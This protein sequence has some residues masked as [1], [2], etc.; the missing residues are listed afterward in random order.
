MDESLSAPVDP[1]ATMQRSR[2]AVVLEPGGMT[3]DGAWWPRSDSL[4]REL[5]ALDVAI[6]DTLGAGISRFSYVLGNW[7]DRPRRIRTATHLIKF[8]WFSHGASPD[9]VELSLRDSRRVVLKVIPPHTPAAE[10]EAFLS[11]IAILRSWPHRSRSGGVTPSGDGPLDARAGAT[12]VIAPVPEGTD[13]STVL[14]PDVTELLDELALID[15]PSMRERAARQVEW[16]AIQWA[17]AAG[18][19]RWAAHAEALEVDGEPP[20]PSRPPWR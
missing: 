5:P 10:A 20:P 15:D 16:R 6:A 17:L 1:Y 2:V 8:G 3:V 4:V 7:S 14:L 18:R 19:V 11:G 9:D 12:G 13:T